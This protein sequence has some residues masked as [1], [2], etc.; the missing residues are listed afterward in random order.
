MRKVGKILCLVAMLAGLLYALGGCET[1]AGVVQMRFS[2]GIG[3]ESGLVCTRPNII[4]S[5][6]RRLILSMKATT[7]KINIVYYPGLQNMMMTKV[8]TLRRVLAVLQGILKITRGRLRVSTSSVQ[9]NT[10]W[11]LMGYDNFGGRLD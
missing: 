8:P 4:K 10:K 2:I 1:W 5:T 7:M 3:M 9:F 6:P 11:G